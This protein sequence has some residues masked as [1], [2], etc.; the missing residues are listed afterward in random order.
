VVTTLPQLAAVA[1][2]ALAAMHPMHTSVAELA[3]AGTTVVV[4]IR[5]F[6]DDF[7]TAVPDGTAQQA[8]P[9]IRSRFELRDSA[10]RPIALRW[11]EIA[12]A[13]DVFQIRLR[14][15]LSQGLA[16][17]RVR[18]L[19]LCEHFPDQVNIVRATYGRRTSSLLFTAGD[20]AKALP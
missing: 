19:L 1:L 4:T 15:D 17:I 13:G 20:Q 14:G 9:Y 5:V 8:E 18:D 10:N 3:P 11:E 6:A 12:R 7:R 2:R 16:G